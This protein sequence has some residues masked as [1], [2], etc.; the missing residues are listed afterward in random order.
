MIDLQ[1]RA[2]IE[3]QGKAKTKEIFK[4]QDKIGEAESTAAA[5]GR[6]AAAASET[7]SK[8]HA[9]QLED[10]LKVKRES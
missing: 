7:H 1:N 6:K 9:A 3:K 8:H 2:S 10:A 5:A 4:L